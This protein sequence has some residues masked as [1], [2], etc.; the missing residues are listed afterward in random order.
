[1]DIGGIV[2]KEAAAGVAAARQLNA[3]DAALADVPQP[4][5]TGAKK[6]AIAP[7]ASASSKGPAAAAPTSGKSSQIEVRAKTPQTTFLTGVGLDAD[8]DDLAKVIVWSFG[9]IGWKCI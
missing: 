4:M 6:V 7:A 1:M 5:N 9:L 3:A 8:D 2:N